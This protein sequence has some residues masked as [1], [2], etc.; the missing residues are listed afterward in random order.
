MSKTASEIILNEEIT[1]SVLYHSQAN[2]IVIFRDSDMVHA[3]ASVSFICVDGTFS[4]CPDT[5]P[6]CHVQR[7]FLSGFSF[8]FPFSLLPD[9]ISYIFNT[10]HIDLFNC[11]TK[12]QL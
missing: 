12:S 1:P 7:R 10:L 2:E 4:L 11:A 5:L 3:A 8:P 6:A 9:K